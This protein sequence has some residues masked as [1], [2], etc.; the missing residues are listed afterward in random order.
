MIYFIIIFL[1]GKQ[2][3]FKNED[4]F[5]FFLDKNRE[6]WSTSYREEKKKYCSKFCGEF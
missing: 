4:F 5:G 2:P 3:I 6:L 1:Q